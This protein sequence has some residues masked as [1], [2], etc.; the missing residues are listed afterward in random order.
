AMGVGVVTSTQG[1]G[2]VP[3]DDTRSLGA[4]NLNKPVERFY[5][6]CD[7]MLVVGSRL[8]GNETLKYELK[9]PR[10]L[11]R[12]DADATAEGRCYPSDFFVCGDSAR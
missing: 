9:L 1:R 2:I 3:E 10:P 6:R 4:F 7:A 11:Y 12:A 8:R 5:Q